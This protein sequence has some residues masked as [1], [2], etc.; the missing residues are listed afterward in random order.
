MLLNAGSVPEG[1]FGRH[2]QRA[3]DQFKGVAF[4]AASRSDAFLL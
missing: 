4:R 3:A 2:N 1:F